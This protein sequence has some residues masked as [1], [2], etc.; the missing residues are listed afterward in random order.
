[1]SSKTVEERVV[2]MKFNNKQFE[3]N[4][5]TSIQTVNNL[6]K[7]L[8]MTKAVKA[9]SNIDS[10]GKNVSFDGLTKGVETIKT[11]FSSLQIMAVTSL[12]NITTS[13]INAGKRIVSAL[14]IDPIKTGFREYETKMN[15][16]QVIQANTRGKNTM[17]DITNALDELNLYADKTIYNFAQMTSNVGKFVAQGLDV[18]QATNAIKGMANLA[19]ASGANAEDMSR[20]TYQISQALGGIIR[21]IDWNS[22]RNANMATTTLKDTL[23]DLARANHVA[24]DAMIKDKGTFEETLEEGWLTG[25]LFTKAMNIYSGVYTDA[26]LK[27]QGFN[28]KQIKNFQELAKTANEAATKVKTITQLWSVLQESAQSG[29]TQSWEYIVGDFDKSKTLLTE[30][31]DAIGGI[32]NDSARTRNALLSAWSMNGGRKALIESFKNVF[33]GIQTYIAPIKEAFR[34]IFPEKSAYQLIKMTE[35]FRDLTAN[36]KASEGTAN[37]IKRIFKGLFSLVDVAGKS[38]A[39]GAKI[40][41]IVLDG[42]GGDILNFLAKVG[43]ALVKYDELLEKNKV[44]ENIISAFSKALVIAGD[45][46]KKTID[47]IVNGFNNFKQSFSEKLKTPKFEGLNTFLDMV[48]RRI[49]NVVSS[50]RNLDNKFSDAFDSMSNK[51]GNTIL[52]KG[53]ET[54]LSVLQKLIEFGGKIGKSLSNNISNVLTTFTDSFANADYST[55]F[56]FVN[57]GLGGAILMSLNQFVKNLSKPLNT[58]DKSI[59]DFVN[60][61][62]TP[63]K[64]LKKIT[65]GIVGILDEV[66]GCFVAYQSQL[67]AGT[68]LKIAGAIAILTG[69]V[70]VLSLIDSKKL[71]DSIIALS[72][73]FANLVG[74]FAILNKINPSITGATKTVGIM[75][76]M[77]VAVLILSSALKKIGELEWST[78]FKG[79]I[80]ITGLFA[81]LITT[82]KLLDGQSKKMFKISTGIIIFAVAINI[83]ASAVKKLGE[84]DFDVLA[85]GLMGVGILLAELGIFLTA[86]EF[87]KKAITNSIGVLILSSA[88]IIMAK[89]VEKLGNLDGDVIMKGLGA[90]LAI[91]A[92]V[93]AFSAFMGMSK[94]MITTS[95]GLVIMGA[96]LNIFATAVGNMGS[97][98]NETLIKGLVGIAAMLAILSVS[99]NLMP[100][101]MPIIGVGLLIVGTALRSLA[102]TLSVVGTIPVKKLLVGLV[103]LVALLTEVTIATTLMQGTMGGALALVVVSLALS[104]FATTLAFLGK[105]KMEEIGKGLLAIAGVFAVLGIAA[106]LLTPVLPAMFGLAG[107]LILISTAVA[108]FGVGVAALGAGIAALAIGIGSLIGITAA[109]A[110]GIVASLTTIII[111]IAGLI[112]AI[113]TQIAKGIISFAKT[114]QEGAPIIATAIITI[115]QSVARAAIECIPIVVNGVFILV[116]TIL[117]SLLEYGPTIISTVLNLVVILLEGL[118]A[119]IPDIT[120]A[121]FELIIAFINGLAIA[122][123]Q[124]TP[125]LIAAFGNLFMALVGALGLIFKSLLETLLD[126]GGKLWDSGFMQGIRNKFSDGYNAVNNFCTTLVGRIKENFDNFK[127]AGGHLIT[128]FING[129]KE[130]VSSAVEAVKDFGGDVIDALMNKLDEHSPSRIS[131]KIGAFFGQG[132]INGLVTLAGAAKAAAKDFGRNSIDGITDSISKIKDFIVSGIDSQPVIRPVLDLSDV[133]SGTKDLKSM[134][135][136]NGGISLAGVVDKVSGLSSKIDNSK[137]IQSETQK[138]SPASNSYQFTQINN[139]PK[140]LSR[141]EIYR[142]T[143]NQFSAMKE[144]LR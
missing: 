126:W 46:I 26:E 76:G 7:N 129:I 57:A 69:S 62:T 19:A 120:N 56:D 113:A 72:T 140:P 12:A 121:A 86:S 82:A 73:L 18:Q 48:Q 79:L 139:S 105:L 136:Q 52:G 4:V 49:E 10:A 39:A 53:L 125:A 100:K 80:G 51:V 8:D 108:L 3:S 116:S 135:N 89:A 85:K 134:I 50:V 128:G 88:L 65:K 5:Q 2:E 98:V 16:I 24:I 71:T 77:S 83:L 35:A 42:S 14:T 25:D 64:E 33:S 11:K 99:L 63:F 9:F 40:I 70:L 131:H 45:V 17:K 15:A 118:T 27:S 109:G 96:A 112:P 61:I 54:L 67:K 29:W 37:D 58:I 138:A 141:L 36:F 132:F 101:N 144:V 21:K 32:L 130:K 23:I 95:I 66:K 106:A 75:I 87:G 22:L 103:G 59:G 81:L 107:V 30:I 43:D 104:T 97:L 92:E 78:M 133:E 117:N 31:S 55:I 114:M 38:I 68:L 20:A 6:K 115:I 111:G 13:A 119:K 94:N 44:F 90:M 47:G 91:L 102:D 137:N 127:E 143:K 34:D 142:Q 84:L 110:A 60:S 41:G 124:N 93:G 122:I 28:D 74:A 123:E 1:M